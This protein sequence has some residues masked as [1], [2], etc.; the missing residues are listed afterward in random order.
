MKNIFA[1]NIANAAADG[2]MTPDGNAYITRR[3]SSSVQVDLEEK[4][5]AAARVERASRL[6]LWLEKYNHSLSEWKNSL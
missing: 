3:A 5:E 4:R 1:F 6:P 2:T